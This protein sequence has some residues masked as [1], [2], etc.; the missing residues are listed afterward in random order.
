M[1]QPLGEDKRNPDKGLPNW[2]VRE[3]LARWLE[4]EGRGVQGL[5]VLDVGCGDK[6]YLPYFAAAA[7]YVG[8][9]VD[10]PHADLQGTIEQL[11]VEDASFD[12]VLCLQ[13]LEHVEDPALAVR[14]LHRV[15][16]LGG[17]V[18]AS[19]HGVQVYHPLPEDHWRWTHTGLERLFNRNGDWHS[20]TVTPGAG[21]CACLGM[22]FGTY[23]HLLAKRA[24][25]AWAARLVN[26]VV[27]RAAAAVDA[28]SHLLREPGPGAM[29][30]NFHVAA[31]R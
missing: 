11:P 3:P 26:G 16:R 31:Q 21:T 17:R 5:R 19:T 20:L 4:E 10:N 8:V 23:I 30:A 14:E 12:V 25:A 6:P 13:V 18:L 15:T 28:R 9:D 29:H 27:N 1:Q 22:L 2:S 7:D 24:H